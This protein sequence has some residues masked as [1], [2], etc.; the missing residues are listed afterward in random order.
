MV[1]VNKLG[2]GLSQY[3]EL[4]LLENRKMSVII[5]IFLNLCQ[6]IQRFPV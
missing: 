3:K 4:I 1:R 5:K 2:L 6:G